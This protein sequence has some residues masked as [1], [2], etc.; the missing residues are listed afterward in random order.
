[1]HH[2]KLAWLNKHDKENGQRTSRDYVLALNFP[3]E[4]KIKMMD[5]VFGKHGSTWRAV[6]QFNK[7]IKMSITRYNLCYWCLKELARNLP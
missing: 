2:T 4:A 7:H 5:E 6:Q 3:K 1:M